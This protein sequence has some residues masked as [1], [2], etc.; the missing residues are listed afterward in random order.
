[1]RYPAGV[2]QHFDA[3]WGWW[4]VAANFNVR[5]ERAERVLGLAERLGE[6]G[7]RL[8]AHHCQWASLFHLGDYDGCCR[9]VEQGLALYDEHAHRGHAS[10]Y[11][12]HD[13]RV[14]GYGELALSQWL[15]GHSVEACENLA[16]SLAW[17]K[18]LQ[19]T[20]SE[21]HARF[22][23]LT[24][25]LYRRDAAIAGDR[26]EAL[27][28]FCTE[29][30]LPDYSANG[31]FFRGWSRAERGNPAAGIADM[32]NA[33]AELTATGTQEDLPWCLSTLAETYLNTGRYDEGL[34]QIAAALSMSDAAGLAYWTA[35]L[36]RCHGELLHATGDPDG[37]AS[38]FHRA[39][40]LASRQ[41]ARF[42]ELR[43]VTG[44]VRGLDG[45]G[46]NRARLGRLLDL[47]AGL[48]DLPDVVAACAALS[49]P[50]PR[51]GL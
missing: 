35:E 40:E 10:I 29:H 24:V 37:A 43:A 13:A 44:L 20:A 2:A 42:F 4:R 11:G 27:I 23:E 8:E 15:L 33:I 38:E 1:M 31:R 50:R 25:D 5:R 45:S 36:H 39:L 16:K 32:R 17:A 9:H 21:A 12:G 49:A 14:C 22:Y 51:D 47:Y 7:Y 26:A 46:E 6:P 48:P 19:H 18:E 34:E 30:G 3:H 28:G 41:K